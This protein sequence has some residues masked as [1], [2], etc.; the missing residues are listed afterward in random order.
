EQVG[1]DR[2]DQNGLADP[3][4]A[5]RSEVP[6]DLTGSHREADEHDVLIA[7]EMVQQRLEI[8]CE[9]VVVVTGRRLARVPESAPVIRDAAIALSKERT[10][11]TLPGG[12][13]ERIPVD[14]N[15]GLAGAAIGVVKLDVGTVFGSN[16]DR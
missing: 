15:D 5:V 11:L 1:R 12:P 13:V 9:R 2:P 10:L 6:G 8:R 14:Q 3:I 4:R 16:I 7:G